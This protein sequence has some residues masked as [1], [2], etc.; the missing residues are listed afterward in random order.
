MNKVKDSSV[1]VV[2]VFVFSINF[3]YHLKRLL[4]I[5]NFLKTEKVIVSHWYQNLDNKLIRECVSVK[6]KIS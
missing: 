2:S 3:C 4:L 1:N 5:S 6:M